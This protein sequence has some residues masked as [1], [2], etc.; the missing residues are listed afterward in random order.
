MRARGPPGL[1]RMTENWKTLLLTVL[2]VSGFTAF[3]F[4]AADFGNN[5]KSGAGLGVNAN[6]IALARAECNLITDRAARSECLAVLAATTRR[7]DAFPV[8][9]NAVRAGIRVAVKARECQDFSGENRTDCFKELRAAAQEQ[10]RER[11]AAHDEL[12][13][14]D[15]ANL[16]ARLGERV[17]AVLEQRKERLETARAAYNKAK[18]RLEAWRQKGL[19]GLSTQEREQY[20]A[21]AGANV[22]AYLES[23]DALADR[24]EASTASAGL[25]ADIRV[26]V[27]ASKADWAAAGTA[28]EKKAVV[29]SVREKWGALK[30]RVNA[31]YVVLEVVRVTTQ[32]RLVLDRANVAIT[33]LG[34]A[35]ANI[36]AL[37]EISLNIEAKIS[38]LE[39]GNY[40][41]QEVRARII[42]LN[43]AFT[44]LKVSLNRAVMGQEVHGLSASV[45]A[46]VPA[47]ADGAGA[48]PGGVESNDAV[49]GSIGV[50]GA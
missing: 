43:R 23:I 22:N 48:V 49:N 34:G 33:A 2:F 26:F 44:H 40:S 17:K 30:E 36:T 45:A 8:A 38:A 28:E 31:E 18:Q 7:V 35:G 24:L 9:A 21:E 32:A 11:L 50:G 41:L 14:Q 4:A 6:A 46:D 29:A 5:V 39:S 16:T 12:G 42:N 47:Q 20:R 10:V 15:A 3:S 1:K 25:V 13:R 27:N 37:S 19:S